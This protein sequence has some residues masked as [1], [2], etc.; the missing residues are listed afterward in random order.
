MIT[1]TGITK[2]Y[3]Q[4]GDVLGSREVRALRGVDFAVPRGGAVSFIGESG[5]GKTTLGR[6]IAG[7]E[8]HDSGEIVIDGTPMT[9]LSPRRRRPYFRRIQ[10]IHQDPYSAL[11]P[12][13]T[14]HQTLRAPLELRARQTGRPGSWIDQRAGELLSLVG[15]DPGYVLG[16]YPH[17]LSG[18][19]RQRVVIARA[20]TVD[21]EMLVADESVSMIDVSMRLSILALLKDLRER[22][23]VSLLFITHDIATARYI[24]DAG[25]L[26]VLYRGQVVER[27]LTE[28]VIHEPVHPYTQALLSAIPVLH[29]L[30]RPGRERVV[31][32]EALDERHADEGCLFA[33]RC[34]F[35]TERCEKELPVLAGCQDSS[36]EHACF[37]PQ[38]RAVIP[39]EA[40]A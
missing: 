25:E 13:R 30:E 4:R 2:T 20:L 32:T 14:I 33:R 16:R 28:S 36:H 37:H 17:Q 34:P 26:Y 12:T 27:G 15:I 10:L 24:G 35:R 29:G 19:M 3:K 18:G 38:R 6:I 8:T 9:P 11:N 21:P 31:P 40:V 7:L 1:G 39:V 5:C 22:L 23:G